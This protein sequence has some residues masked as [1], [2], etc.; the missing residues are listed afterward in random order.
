VRGARECSAR[1]PTNSGGCSK[2]RLGGAWG[3]S[4]P[5]VAEDT[6]LLSEYNVLFP[7]Y[8]R[9]RVRTV[10]GR[11]RLWREQKSCICTLDIGIF[12]APFSM[13]R[14]KTPFSDRIQR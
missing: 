5:H 12:R 11:A 6:S 8:H 13:V 14:V 4:A 7:R 1:I 9:V 2:P 3:G 10:S